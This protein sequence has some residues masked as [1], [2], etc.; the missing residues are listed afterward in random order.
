M[1]EISSNFG[2]FSNYM[3]VEEMFSENKGES[4]PEYFLRNYFAPKFCE[5][6]GS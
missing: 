3:D 2:V 1:K 4:K 5:S 6:R